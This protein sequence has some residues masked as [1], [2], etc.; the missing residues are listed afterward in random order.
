MGPPQNEG[1]Q[2]KHHDGDDDISHCTRV[3]AV[4][5]ARSSV[6]FRGKP[7]DAARQVQTS[8]QTALQAPRQLTLFLPA[9]LLDLVEPA[10]FPLRLTQRFPAIE[11][12]QQLGIDIRTVPD[13]PPEERQLVVAVSYFRADVC[14][15]ATGIDTR[16]DPVQ[17]TADLFG[18]PVVECPERAIGTAVARREPPMQIEDAQPP[19]FSS[20]PRISDVPKTA[21]T[22]G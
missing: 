12:L 10:S 7:F 4:S 9:A 22:S 5:L 3:R 6:S 21:M 14:D 11:P 13:G 15:E 20:G 17:R 1:Q 8:Q 19:S 18:L 16:I 2:S